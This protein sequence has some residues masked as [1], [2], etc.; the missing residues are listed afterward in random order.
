MKATRSYP[1]EQELSKAFKAGALSV[2]PVTVNKAELR[3]LDAAERKVIEAEIGHNVL[4]AAIKTGLSGQLII[5]IQIKPA[6]PE[7]E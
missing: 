7:K 2:Q 5:S 4:E 6:T 1:G 3:K